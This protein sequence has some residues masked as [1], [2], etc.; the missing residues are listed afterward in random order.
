MASHLGG[1]TRRVE[2][3]RLITG[4]G[5]YAADIHPEGQVHV[6]FC[7]SSLPHARIRGIDRSVAAGM[8]GVLAVW[9]A[10][11]LPEVAAGLSD[12]G[13]PGIEQRGRPILNREEVNYVG[14]AFALVAAETP[15]QAMDAA[16]QVV[17][18]LDPLIGVGDVAAAT[19]PGA[20]TVHADMKS[21]IAQT[22]SIAYGDI[23]AAFEPDS[24]TAKVRLTTS[25]VAGAAMEPRTVTVAPDRETG[26]LKVWTST[27]NVFGVRSAIASALGLEEGN[28]RVLAQDVGGG[29]GA[30]GTPFPE[31]VLTA[32]AAWRLKRPARW[33]GSR[34]ED[35]ATT[36]QGHGSIIELALASD[37]AGKLR[38][39]R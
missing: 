15:Y 23:K 3:R 39:L 17:A 21:N 28:V 5:R 19:M 32:I 9:T 29:F 14:E 25:R 18:E 31:E 8:P 11:D 12:F 4:R 35:G 20:A 34:S 13:P 1:R 7:R 30:K 33:V 37:R 6:V 22:H 36:A 24:V 10:D 38:G 27:Q 16:E 26:G 2:D